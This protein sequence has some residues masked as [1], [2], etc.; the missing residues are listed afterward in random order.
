MSLRQKLKEIERANKATQVDVR[1]LVNEWV[2]AVHEL[3]ERVAHDLGDLIQDQVINVIRQP[4]TRS[5]ERT[6]PYQIYELNLHVAGKT[7]AF[8]PV[9]LFVV[10]ANGR[11]DLFAKG[12]LDTRY[13]LLRLKG[14]HGGSDRWFIT[15]ADTLRKLPLPKLPELSRKN[16]EDAIETL[17]SK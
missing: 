5:E 4:V 12:R 9:A 14:P 3:Y 15:R 16:L 7:I 2:A 8:N 10:G 1:R 13:H 11:V 6:G 17:V